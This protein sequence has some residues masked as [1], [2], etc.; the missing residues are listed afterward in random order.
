M[1]TST[2]YQTTRYVTVTNVAEDQ[3][4]AA[5]YSQEEYYD[6]FGSNLVLHAPK[7]GVADGVSSSSINA[8]G[9]HAPST[10]HSMLIFINPS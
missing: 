9:S 4:A 6:G 1:K 7:N 3:I 8:K 10:V 5:P 2:D